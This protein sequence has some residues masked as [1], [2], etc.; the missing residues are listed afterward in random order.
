MV[1]DF[2]QRIGLEAQRIDTI[3]RDLLDFARPTALTLAPVA[4]AAALDAAARL[5]RVQARF[6]DVALELDLPAEL[7]L[8][9]ADERRLAQVFLNLLLNAGDAMAGRGRVV[10][11]GRAEGGRVIVEV[12]DS[13]PGLSP[14]ARPRIFDPFFTTKEPGQGTGLGLAVCHGIMESFGG[15][16]EAGE[17]PGG[18]VRFTLRLRA[19]PL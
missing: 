10:V 8:V 6:R 13:G 9:R 4:V 14:E 17:A 2:L 7:P 19:E 1:Q 15:A 5:A 12:D 16:I 3:V 11:A 18:G